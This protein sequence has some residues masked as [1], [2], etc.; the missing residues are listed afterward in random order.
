MRFGVRVKVSIKT[1]VKVRVTIALNYN[2]LRSGTEVAAKVG[3]ES[4]VTNP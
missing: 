4:W 2:T 1:S 3:L